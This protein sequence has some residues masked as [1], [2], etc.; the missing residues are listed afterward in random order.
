MNVDQ[1]YY[2]KI[3]INKVFFFV[4]MIVL[5]CGVSTLV[6]SAANQAPV[7][8][9]QVHLLPTSSLYFLKEWK[10]GIERVF[11]KNPEDRVKL[12]ISIRD[13]RAAEL[14]KLKGDIGVKN[15]TIQDAV[16][17]YAD[18]N[19]LVNKSISDL[20][21]ADK[22]KALLYSKDD[23]VHVQAHRDILLGLQDKITD[24]DTKVALEKIIDKNFSVNKDSTDILSQGANMESDG[25]VELGDIS[26]ELSD[27]FTI[28]VDEAFLSESQASTTTV[29]TSLTKADI[30]YC[31]KL[32]KTANDYKEMHDNGTLSAGDFDAKAKVLGNDLERCR[33]FPSKIDTTIATSGSN[34][35]PCD[36]E[37]TPVCGVDGVTYS[38]VCMASVAGVEVEVED[39]CDTGI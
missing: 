11:T 19:T 13:E 35:V 34:T 8:L 17:G 12:E 6:A 38:N 16:S 20:E 4:L 10:R 1:R 21:I 7:V 18:S 31:G 32:I 2:L 29:V 37:Y 15:E 33:A 30:S 22:E 23:E 28:Y 26:K 5:L 25:D 3:L 14:A 24:P 27:L 9:P 36:T 39:A